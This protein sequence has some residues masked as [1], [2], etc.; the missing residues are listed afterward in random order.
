MRGDDGACDFC[1]LLKTDAVR[2]LYGRG[3]GCPRLLFF[4]AADRPSAAQEKSH[5][6]RSRPGLSYQDSPD[7]ITMMTGVR[8]WVTIRSCGSRMRKP[9]N[10][11]I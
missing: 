3:P 7:I 11:L 2:V 6:P 8:S 5:Q 10:G 9:Q 1:S 4:W